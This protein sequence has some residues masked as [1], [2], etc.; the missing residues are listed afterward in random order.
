MSRL[1]LEIPNDVAESLQLPQSERLSR[2]QR[3]LA[4][5]LYQK[6]LLSFGRAREL[7][8]MTK[9]E[10]HSL[11]GDEAIE[12]SYDLE[13]LDNDLNTLEHLA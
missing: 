10:F 9:W 2:I 8:Q 11:L 1:V 12:R 13:E 7:A 3:E 5:R 6:G 4:V